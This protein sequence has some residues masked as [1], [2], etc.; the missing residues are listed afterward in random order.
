MFDS[1]HIWKFMMKI[2]NNVCMIL[3]FASA[4]PMEIFQNEISVDD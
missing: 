2:L 3:N 1:M 4:L